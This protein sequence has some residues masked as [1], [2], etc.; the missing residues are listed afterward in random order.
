MTMQPFPFLDPN[1]LEATDL[2]RQTLFN[3]FLPGNAN[4]FQQQL[5]GQLF[6]PTFN[7][8]LGQLGSQIKS[9]QAPTLTFNNFLNEQFNP[10][11]ALLR[12]PDFG[13]GGGFGPTLFN[14]GGG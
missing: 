11:R 9:G 7:Q 10:Q 5:F 3:S 14:F 2:G 4:P 6:E 12:L 13:K 8:F 1:E